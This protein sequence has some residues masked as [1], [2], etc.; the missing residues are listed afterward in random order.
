MNFDT[1][2]S[3]DVLSCVSGSTRDMH[4]TTNATRATRTTCA[5]SIKPI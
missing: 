1:G 2:K 3:R 5:R 4:V